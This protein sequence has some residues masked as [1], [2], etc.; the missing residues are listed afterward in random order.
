MQG[1]NKVLVGKLVQD[2]LLKRGGTAVRRR[3]RLRNAVQEGQVR[4]PAADL[5][6]IG[7]QAVAHHLPRVGAEA[8]RFSGVGDSSP[9]QVDAA[10]L[11]D[12]AVVE[13]ADL[14]V[15]LDVVPDDPIDHGEVMLDQTA[16][17]LC[18]SHG[19]IHKC[20]LLSHAAARSGGLVWEHMAMSR[21]HW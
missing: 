4:V 6:A 10:L 5:A 2:L 18:Q 11:I 20:R 17:G 19:F 3:L 9:T 16:L 21:S 8:G 13:P 15:E 14:G 7:D 1:T 12:V